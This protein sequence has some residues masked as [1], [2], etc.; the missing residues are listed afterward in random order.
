MFLLSFFYQSLIKQLLAE[1]ERYIMT[2][3]PILSYSLQATYDIVQNLCSLVVRFIFQPLEESFYV[4]F[5][6]EVN[7]YNSDKNK[8]KQVLIRLL[9]LLLL[10][11]ILLFLVRLF[12]IAIWLLL[13]T[14]IVKHIFR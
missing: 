9:K 11:N 10:V 7:S 4:Y 12:Y 13:L 5:A 14:N 2:I 8:I 6:Q 3:F 1:S